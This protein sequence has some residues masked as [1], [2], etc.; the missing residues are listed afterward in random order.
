MAGS[1]GVAEESKIKPNR[2]LFCA[3]VINGDIV[4]AI[5]RLRIISGICINMVV[6]LQ[7]PIRIRIALRLKS[8]IVVKVILGKRAIN[9]TFG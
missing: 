8:V 6:T 4:V 2:K 3:I 5:R 7:D 9:N 1:V